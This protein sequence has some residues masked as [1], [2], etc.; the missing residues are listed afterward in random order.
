MHHLLAAL[1]F[2]CALPIYAHQVI[3]IA[4][5]DTLTLLV[6]REPLKIRLADIDAPEKK[7]PYGQRSKESLSSLCWGKDATYQTQT[8]DRYGRTVARVTCGGIDVNR[9]QV[10]RGMAWTYDKYN[11]DSSLP[12]AQ[13]AARSGRKGLWA[14][15]V[16]MPPWEFRHPV[17]Q[18]GLQ[19]T[20]AANDATCH[21]G[22]RGGK[23]QII[24]G[25]KRYG[26]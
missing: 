22:P 13:A 19:R 2:V 16:P 14:D 15:S 20:P 5:G 4:D 21:T 8:V 10:A 12:S 3:S 11:T 25:H 17:K 23:Y 6:K 26:C 9:A 24:N 7:Q 1:L 18:T